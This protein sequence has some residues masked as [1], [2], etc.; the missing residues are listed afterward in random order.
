MSGESPVAR[1][2][3]TSQRTE[4]TRMT[5][6]VDAAAAK[7]PGDVV[8]CSGPAPPAATSVKR[9]GSWP[10]SMLTCSIACCRLCS[11][12][13]MM[14]EAALTV[15]M[16][17]GAGDVGARPRPARAVVEGNRA[18]GETPG[19]ETAQHQVRVG[20]GR[21]RAAE[22]VAGWPR[23]GA[24]PV[25]TDLQQAAAIDTRDGPSAAADGVNVDRRQREMIVVQGHLIDHRD[26]APVH[27][28][29]VAARASDLHQDQ[30]VGPMPSWRPR[31]ARS[32][33]RPGRT[34]PA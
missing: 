25:R 29:D 23:P 30:L 32:R 34:G 10:R 2:Q 20:D 3:C 21:V 8:A 24:R 14:P 22:P 11:S 17:S 33:P 12:S 19:A 18:V 5:R 15:S 7:R 27:E 9:R 31:A 26:L 28:R 4:H 16:P 13:W 6:D 1:R